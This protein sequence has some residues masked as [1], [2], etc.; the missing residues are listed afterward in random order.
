MKLP[1][2]TR[3]WL[4]LKITHVESTPVLEGDLSAVD[5][6]SS[7]RVVERK[8]SGAMG[9]VALARKTSRSLRS[10]RFKKSFGSVK[11]CADSEEKEATSADETSPNTEAE[12]ANYETVEEQINVAPVEDDVLSDEK[13]T[14]KTPSM[15]EIAKADEALA[16]PEDKHV[17]STP[18]LEGDLSAVES[19]DVE[20]KRSGA[21]GSRYPCQKD[22]S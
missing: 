8:R 3:P 4:H 16:P 13:E 17:E 20:R 18:V 2:L 19:Q 10:T 6:F 5:D 15:N 22:E 9:L 21:C 12:E 11:P 1:K 7:S 14:I